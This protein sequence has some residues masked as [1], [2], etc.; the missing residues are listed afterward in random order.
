MLFADE[1]RFM[2]YREDGRMRVWRMRGKALRE[3]DMGKTIAY[4]GGSFHVWSA[5]CSV[6]KVLWSYWIGKSMWRSTGTF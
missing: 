1:S 4:E 5:I 2:L 6:E 3:G